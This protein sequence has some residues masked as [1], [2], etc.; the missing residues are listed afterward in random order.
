[1]PL[2]LSI[3]LNVGNNV[4]LHLSDIAGTTG[5]SKRLDILGSSGL[6]LINF[7][8]GYRRCVPNFHDLFG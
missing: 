8:R 1:M 6:L 3:S 2:Y 7:S 5:I 4:R